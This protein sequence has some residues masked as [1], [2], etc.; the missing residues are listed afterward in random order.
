MLTNLWTLYRTYIGA[1]GNGLYSIP[2]KFPNDFKVHVNISSEQSWLDSQE[3]SDSCGR[4]KACNF[5]KHSLFYNIPIEKPEESQ[6]PSEWK[7]WFQIQTKKGVDVKNDAYLAFA[8][9]PFKQPG[10]QAMM[11]RAFN[12]VKGLSKAL[13]LNLV[14]G[15]APDQDAQGRNMNWLI[16]GYWLKFCQQHDRQDNDWHCACDCL[17]FC[18]GFCSQWCDPQYIHLLFLT[19]TSLLFVSN[20]LL[21]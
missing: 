12:V 10:I 17:N 19:F 16:A 14:H 20:V 4:P 5:A 2:V 21:L 6:M 3:W 1:N 7:R 15:S 11:W 8:Y 13:L 9:K 18:S